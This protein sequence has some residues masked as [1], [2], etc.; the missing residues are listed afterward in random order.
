[1]R[2][3]KYVRQR[4]TFIHDRDGFAA[5]VRRLLL[6]KAFARDNQSRAELPLARRWALVAV[7]SL[8]G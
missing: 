8:A 6:P 7:G 1:M 3:R 2:K 5:F 4:N